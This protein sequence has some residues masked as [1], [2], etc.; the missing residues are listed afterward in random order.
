MNNCRE[1]A[2]IARNQR[3]RREDQVKLRHPSYP[4][5]DVSTAGGVLKKTPVLQ[6]LIC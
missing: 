2:R 6:L 1:K 4:T 3:A 5:R